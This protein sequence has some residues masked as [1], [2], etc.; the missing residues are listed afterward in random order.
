MRK[1]QYVI[2]NAVRKPLIPLKLIRS[3][4]YIPLEDNTCSFDE[5]GY[6]IPEGISL[7]N[8]NV[9][10]AILCNYSKLKQGA[11]GRFNADT[12]YLLYDFE[13]TCDRAL[14]DY[15]LYMRIVEYKID[16]LSNL[17]I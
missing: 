13:N 11:E 1:D 4:H 8:P 9:C 14:K 6:P 15:P 16:N 5:E 12:W 3:E 7:M 17:E 2:K 10:S